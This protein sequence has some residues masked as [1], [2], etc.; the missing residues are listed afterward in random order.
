MISVARRRRLAPDRYRRVWALVEYIAR[1]PGA[2]RR[3]LAARF[4]LSERQLQADLELIRRDLRLPLLRRQ[5]YRFANAADGATFGLP[6][7]VL[8]ARALER[9]AAAEPTVGPAVAALAERLPA[10]LPTHLEA[11][12]RAVLATAAGQPSDAA[13]ALAF[14][15]LAEALAR[16]SAVRV[17]YQPTPRGPVWETTLAVELVLPLDDSLYLLGECQQRRKPLLVDLDTVLRL[18]LVEDAPAT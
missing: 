14:V 15:V 3:A 8:L 9:T 10:V 5:G 13:R 2:T 17:R 7:L 16:R 11:L 6:D 18:A 4:A 12:A 1:E